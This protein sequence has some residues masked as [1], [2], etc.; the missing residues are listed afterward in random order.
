MGQTGSDNIIF[1]VSLKSLEWLGSLLS[2]GHSKTQICCDLHQSIVGLY[3]HVLGLWVF[4]L[5]GSKSLPRS[6]LLKLFIFFF[7]KCTSIHGS[8][9][10]S[11]LM[12]K[13]LYVL[14]CKHNHLAV[15]MFC[16]LF[17]VLLSTVT[18]LSLYFWSF[19]CCSGFWYISS[20]TIV[21]SFSHKANYI[22]LTV[23]L[24]SVNQTWVTNMFWLHQKLQIVTAIEALQKSSVNIWGG[25]VYCLMQWEQCNMMLIRDLLLTWDRRY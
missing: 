9:F 21:I 8:T 3:L 11:M 1:Q 13:N 12:K 25:I 10:P 2:L 18:F 23:S 24:I 6:F 5:M 15:G 17:N 14:K 7:S 22:A 16:P 20:R 19:I 4:M